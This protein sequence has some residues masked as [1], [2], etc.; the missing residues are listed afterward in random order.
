MNRKDTLY[1]DIFF[2]CKVN[3]FLSSYTYSKCLIDIGWFFLMDP[4][5]T[6]CIKPKTYLGLYVLPI[7]FFKF[8]VFIYHWKTGID[9]IRMLDYHH[10]CNI[11]TIIVIYFISNIVFSI[12]PTD[13]FKSYSLLLW[14]LLCYF[15]RRYILQMNLVYRYHLYFLMCLQEN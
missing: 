14:K 13:N 15:H 4:L 1:Q 12:L 3:P 5:F 7:E 2:R 6:C 11:M 9:R 8:R 10:F